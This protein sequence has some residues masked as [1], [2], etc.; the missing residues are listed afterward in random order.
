MS[1][2]EE[3][4]KEEFKAQKKAAKKTKNKA[5]GKKGHLFVRIT[6]LIGITTII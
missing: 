2:I 4:S 5:S 3:K 1:D 6:L